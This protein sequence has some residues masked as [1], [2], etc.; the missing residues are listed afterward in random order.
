M[1]T[2]CEGH[3]GDAI[4]TLVVNCHHSGLSG[5]TEKNAGSVQ[6]SGGYAVA[7]LFEAFAGV[8]GIILPASLWPWVRLGL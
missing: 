7:Q 3:E 4:V 6:F 1:A 8:I 2:N 5:E